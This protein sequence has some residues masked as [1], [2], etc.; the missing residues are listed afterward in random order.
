MSED[1]ATSGEPDAGGDVSALEGS[2]GSS[3]RSPRNLLAAARAKPRRATLFVALCGL[4]V[5]GLIAVG[6]AYR[7]NSVSVGI[8]EPSS[9]VLGSDGIPTQVDGQRVYRV[10]EKAEWQNLNGSFLLGGYALPSSWMCP[11]SPSTAPPAE[12]DLLDTCYGPG[13]AARPNVGGLNSD[14]AWL[15]PLGSDAVEGWLD[16]PPIVVRVHA[17]DWEAA[18]CSTYFK[19]MCVAAI[20]VES[21][22]CPVL[23]T[24]I[25]GQRVYR[26]TDKVAFPTSGSFLLG[27]PFEKPDVVP[28]C[29]MQPG[30]STAEQQLIPYCYIL[31][32]DDL[33]L[34]PMSTI[35]EPKDELVVARVHVNDP[36]A[37]KCPSDRQRYCDSAIVVESVVWRSNPYTIA[38]PTPGRT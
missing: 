18:G 12:A 28:P 3:T 38:L 11:R 29:P 36:E 14:D 35:A 19:A 26:Q 32:I 37:A 8:A 33:N 16:G 9:V 17:H 34:A 5:V 13:L 25:R 7:P 30:P 15:A 4:A 27:G 1:P 31:S 21:V 22:V 24:E 10:G 20:V 23:P 2:P 6:L